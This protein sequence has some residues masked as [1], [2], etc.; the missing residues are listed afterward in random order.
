MQ[1]TSNR[2]D[3]NV[4]VRNTRSGKVYGGDIS[5]ALANKRA[6]GDI[7]NSLPPQGKENQKRPLRDLL[8]RRPSAPTHST[9]SS[10][11]TTTSSSSTTSHGSIRSHSFS[12][13]SMTSASLSTSHA[14][15]TAHSA[16]EERRYSASQLDHHLLD[17]IPKHDPSPSL[18]Q[19]LPSSRSIAQSSTTVKEPVVDIDAADAD[20]TQCVGE[21][22][23]EIYDNLR[24]TETNHM[25]PPT[26]M[27]HQPDISAKMR[28]IL[29]DWLVDVHLKFRLQPET[30]HLTVNLIDRFLAVKQVPRQKLQLVGVTAM[31]LAS[32]YEE[33]YAPE[34]KDFVYISD[35][36]Y[37]RE[38]ILR[39]EAVMLNKLGF[40]LTTSSPLTFLKR[41]LKAA[42]CSHDKRFTNFSSYLLEL[43][44]QDYKMLK[45]TPSMIAASCAYLSLRL[46][47]RGS[48]NTTLEHYS[49]YT[50]SQLK[51]CVSDLYTVAKGA[52]TAS[53]RA[54]YRKYGNAKY[55]SVSHLPLDLQ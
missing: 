5:G 18:G 25:P 40:N 8:R 33:I 30:M 43:T 54:V 22:I 50:E 32:K 38:D 2:Y 52:S 34:V 19:N 55:N 53:L 27:V 13:R 23:T 1:T 17:A 3:E 9:S 10:T 16:R 12:E 21:Y 39:M 46:T 4:F 42:G 35:R 20:D 24:K 29:M 15:H 45:Y 49:Q 28:A 44:M 47:R 14:S 6:L 51:Q 37:T 26:Y 48:W 11:V 41:F 31:L 7:S 36:V